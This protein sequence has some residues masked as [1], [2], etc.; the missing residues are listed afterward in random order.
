M[1]TGKEIKISPQ[2]RGVLKVF[3]KYSG[4]SYKT[5][6]I[7]YREL[8]SFDQTAMCIDLACRINWPVEQL[9]SLIAKAGER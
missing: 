8:E 4:R 3:A 7:A 6:Q 9:A 1:S 2:Q 5:V